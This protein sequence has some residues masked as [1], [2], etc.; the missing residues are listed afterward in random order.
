M[1][2]RLSKNL[3]YLQ[4]WSLRTMTIIHSKF[5][6]ENHRCYPFPTSNT[7]Q[8]TPWCC[9]LGDHNGGPSPPAQKMGISGRFK[10]WD[11]VS[12][13]S[14][15]K[16]IWIVTDH[17]S[18]CK[19]VILGW[20]PYISII[21]II[22][23]YLYPFKHIIYVGILSQ[24]DVATTMWSLGTRRRTKPLSAW[25]SNRKS[26]CC[27]TSHVSWLEIDKERQQFCQKSPTKIVMIFSIPFHLFGDYGIPN[28]D[29]P[30]Q[31]ERFL[32]NPQRFNSF[33]AGALLITSSLDW[34][35]PKSIDK[36]TCFHHVF[37]LQ[38]KFNITYF[39]VCT[40]STSQ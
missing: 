6:P 38:I 26:Y 40:Y 20:F 8:T 12:A 16:V 5:F 10:A 15:S 32:I 7:T 33:T 4:I 27:W 37:L 9:I 24:R 13:L 17:S 31:S 11:S 36:G 19:E 25:P 14:I 18:T 3:V 30:S 39:L 22:Y 28:P 1:E 23:I 35:C 29:W 2:M 34:C 21:Y